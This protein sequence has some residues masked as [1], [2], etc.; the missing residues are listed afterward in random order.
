MQVYKP[1]MPQCANLSPATTP[2]GV[3]HCHLMAGTL[4]LKSGYTSKKGEAGRNII[5]AE[6]QLVLGH[7]SLPDGARLFSG[8]G[9]ASR[10]NQQENYTAHRK[11]AAKSL[12]LCDRPAQ[13]HHVSGA[14]LA[15]Q[16]P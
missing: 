7:T 11:A 16:L 10:P 6:G 2:F 12:A 1:S 14:V 3:T 9:V 5:G 13:Q 8:G 4:K 15:P